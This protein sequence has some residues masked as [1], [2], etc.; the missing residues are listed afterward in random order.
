[1]QFHPLSAIDTAEVEHVVAHA[2]VRIE[3]FLARRGF[4][5]GEDG[6]GRG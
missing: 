5:Q 1:L 2:A 4:G 3:R 6:R